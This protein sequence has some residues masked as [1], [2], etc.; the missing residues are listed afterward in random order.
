MITCNEYKVLTAIKAATES[1][2]GKFVFKDEIKIPHLDE[3]EINEIMRE[4]YRQQHITN[5]FNSDDKCIH[6]AKIEDSGLVEI[7]N[8]KKNLIKH[9]LTNYVWVLITIILTAILTGYFTHLFTK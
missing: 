6:G 4:L 9:I 7:K 8:Y 2:N 3:F 1:K 5:I